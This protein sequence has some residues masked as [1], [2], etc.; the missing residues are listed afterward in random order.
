M[1]ELPVGSKRR[2]KTGHVLTGEGSMTA[3]S[4]PEGWEFTVTAI[5]ARE[6]KVWL[7]FGDPRR[8]EC[9][10]SDIL[11]NTEPVHDHTLDEGQEW[12]RGLPE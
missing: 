1:N 10:V 8:F 4:Y 6:G 3:G 12:K 9:Y 2:I 5:K 7:D 11:K